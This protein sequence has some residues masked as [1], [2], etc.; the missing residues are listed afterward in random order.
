EAKEERYTELVWNQESEQWKSPQGETIIGNT[1]M[2]IGGSD[3]VIRWE[4]PRSGKIH[5][6]GWASMLEGNEGDGVNLRLLKNDTQIWPSAGWQS[7]AFNDQI[8][9]ELAQELEV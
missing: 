7:I 4:A 9:V 6:G 3:P 8:G 5:V 2:H 1:W